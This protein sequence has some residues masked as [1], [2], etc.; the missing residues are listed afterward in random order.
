MFLAPI[1][2]QGIVHSEGEIATARG[3]AKAGVPMIMS[4]ASTRTIEAVA[5]AS[6]DGH[7]W[8]QLYW[9]VS[10]GYVNSNSS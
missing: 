9:Y 3:A 2:V 1:G 10:L 7:R 4:T 6:G 5:Q 8:Y